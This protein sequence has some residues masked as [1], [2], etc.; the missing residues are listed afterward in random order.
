MVWAW[1]TGSNLR[2]AR[3]TSMGSNASGAASPPSRGVTFSARSDALDELDD[4]EP[5]V[6]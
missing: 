3:A 4:L 6:P 1:Q 2:R 5:A